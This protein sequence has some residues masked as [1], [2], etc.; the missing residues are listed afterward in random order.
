M[1]QQTFNRAAVAKK[2]TLVGAGFNLFLAIIKVLFGWLGRS[3]ALIADGIHSL[4]DLLTDALVLLASHF[5]SRKA[6]I[7]H[8]YGHQ[9]IETA[10]TL[11]LALLLILAGLGIAFDAAVHLFEHAK[12]MPKFYVLIIAVISILANEGLYHYTLSAGKKIQSNLLIANAWHHRSD[13]LSSIVVLIGIIGALVGYYYLDS[14]AAI[15]VGFMIVKMGGSLGWSSVRELVDT[16]VPVET[17]NEIRACILSVP[18]VVMVHELRTRCMAE[19]ILVDAHILVKPRLSVSEG[20]YISSKVHEKLIKTFTKLVDV[21]IHVDPENDEVAP[22]S[23]NLPPRSE[24]TAIIRS[25]LLNYAYVDAIADVRLH[26]LEGKIFV[27]IIFPLMVLS[28]Y[29]ITSETLLQQSRE[30]LEKIECVGHVQVLY[31]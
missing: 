29:A 14:V 10:A 25:H 28:E 3:H 20:H 15:I 23:R 19:E 4:S 6:D 5:G 31:V 17:L 24:I 8:P 11:F 12:Q 9:R 13:A 27:E 26:Y 2:V 21:T 30:A 22:L 18:G 16:G 1:T 7:D